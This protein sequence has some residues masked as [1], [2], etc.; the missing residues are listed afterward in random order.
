MYQY[1]AHKANLFLLEV[2]I[3]YFFSSKF[4]FACIFAEHIS[5]L[6]SNQDLR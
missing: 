6:V 1:T 5:D 2:L 3:L 4:K